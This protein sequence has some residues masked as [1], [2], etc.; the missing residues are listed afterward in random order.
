VF[1][2]LSGESGKE[3]S[4]LI[5]TLFRLRLGGGERADDAGPEHAFFASLSLSH[6]SREAARRGG[7]SDSGRRR[8]LA[9]RPLRL[10]RIPGP[11]A[12]GLGWVAGL[13]SRAQIRR[14][15][16]RA[17][18]RPALACSGAEFPLI[19]RTGTVIFFF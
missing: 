1:A 4:Q 19:S 11:G 3:G 15:R 16:A 10:L 12:L 6:P 17:D 5:E 13:R 9:G 14:D 18:P 2:V 8:L 7:G